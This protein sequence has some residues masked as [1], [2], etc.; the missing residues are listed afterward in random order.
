M[1]IFRRRPAPASGSE[2]GLA[3]DEA[4]TIQ[5]QDCSGCGRHYPLV[6]ALVKRD[7]DAHAVAFCALH[8]HDDV[9]EAWIDVIL[10]TFGGGATPD[11]LTFGC[12]VGPVG[13]QDEPAATAVDAAEPYGDNPIWGR[14]LGRQD[15]LAHPRL[16]EFWQVVD[17]IL[18]ADPVVHHHVYGHEPDRV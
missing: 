7:G 1:P 11:N 8:T 2:A 6:K 5:E 12:R 16:A 15:A 9:R 18:V 4:P 13:G 3:F 14:K 10:G 17:F